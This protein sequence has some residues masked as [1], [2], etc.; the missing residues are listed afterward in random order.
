MTQLGW[1]FADKLMLL[2]TAVLY[3]YFLH[4]TMNLKFMTDNNDGSI[5]CLP[6]SA[7]LG[8][9]YEFDFI[10]GHPM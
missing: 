2:I 10:Y 7:G 3:F 6:V 9:S 1:L 5:M 4:D 8:S